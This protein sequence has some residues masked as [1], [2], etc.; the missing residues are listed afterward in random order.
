MADAGADTK[1]KTDPPTTVLVLS[2]LF[3]LLGTGLV[4]LSGLGLATYQGLSSGLGTTA[5]GG[6]GEGWRATVF[7]AL[8]WIDWFL[9][10]LGLVGMSLLYVALKFYRLRAWARLALEVTV[11]T[12]LGITA[13]GAVVW[14]RLVDRLGVVLRSGGR[15]LSAWGITYLMTVGL[16]A[17]ACVFL[18]LMAALF[19]L[20]S[21]GVR[22]AVRTDE[23]SDGNPDSRSVREDGGSR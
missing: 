12:G 4:F 6:G 1:E 10:G 2:I 16:M 11:W 20:R 23:A 3:G 5:V 22:A 14:Y 8:R 15:N 21:A 9:A 18:A 13:A 7:M 17:V 19:H